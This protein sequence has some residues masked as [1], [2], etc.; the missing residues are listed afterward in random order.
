MRQLGL[1]QA[2]GA[3]TGQ[4]GALSFD[5]ASQR[6]EDC[7]HSRA[8]RIHAI[9]PRGRQLRGGVHLSACLFKEAGSSFFALD[10]WA[11]AP[12][13]MPQRQH[14][15]Q[16]QVKLNLVSR[17]KGIDV[18]EWP[19]QCEEHNGSRCSVHAR[20][21]ACCHEMRMHRV[22]APSEPTIFKGRQCSM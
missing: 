20:G 16:Y 2:M 7:G 5:E 1:R 14:Q 22:G 15:L 21:A 10:K 17:V 9:E 13:A 4:A 11:I 18:D 8:V 19:K 3:S 6:E 12:L